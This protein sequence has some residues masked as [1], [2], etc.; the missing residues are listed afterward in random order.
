MGK[1]AREKGGLKIQITRGATFFRGRECGLML[2]VASM[3]TE[4]VDG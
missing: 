2:S 4:V 1:K 3:G